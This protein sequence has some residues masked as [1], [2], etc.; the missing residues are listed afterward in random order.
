MLTIKAAWESPCFQYGQREERIRSALCSLKFPP[1]PAPHSPLVIP[2]GKLKL[3]EG[4][5]W[6][7]APCTEGP[8]PFQVPC[9][10]LQN[11]GCTASVA[12]GA[13][14][15]HLSL[16]CA[17]SASQLLYRRSCSRSAPPPP[18]GQCSGPGSP[19]PGSPT[20]QLQ[21]L[22]AALQWMLETRSFPGLLYSAH[23]LS[24]LPALPC[25]LGQ[26][27]LPV[28][29]SRFPAQLSGLQRGLW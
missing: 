23:S 2:M 21:L 14:R 13:W 26:A 12:P 15:Y 8:C 29:E 19:A 7:K 9:T 10:P 6:S 18:L 25:N 17:N 5:P 1:L 11:L 27:E 28:S 16:L 4:R 20:P 24:L 3:R 22:C